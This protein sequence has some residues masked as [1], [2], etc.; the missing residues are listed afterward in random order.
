MS[1]DNV[2]KTNG[3][4]KKL[5][6][7][8]KFLSAQ[9]KEKILSVFSSIDGQEDDAVQDNITTAESLGL[10]LRETKNNLGDK[11]YDKFLD[12]AGLSYLKN[13]KNSLG[14]LDDD[15]LSSQQ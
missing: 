14:C 1:F 3:I 2:S 8:N 13:D 4:S 9:E 12:S 11:R 6:E 10:F 5:I 7:Q 15:L